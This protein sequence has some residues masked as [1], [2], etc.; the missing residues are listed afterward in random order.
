[1]RFIAA[2]GFLGAFLAAGLL[3]SGATLAG[4][5]RARNCANHDGASVSVSAFNANDLIKAIPKTTLQIAA[6]SSAMLSCGTELC[7]YSVTYPTA[8]QSSS[9][10]NLAMA[11]G[12]AAPTQTFKSNRTLDARTICFLF[13]YDEKGTI[14][15]SRTG[16]EVYDSCN[17]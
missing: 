12:G 3:P 4:E 16:S 2:A 11:T 17:C 14:D 13:F 8:L 5:F 6:G 1:M 7:Q 10:P 9:M 15:H